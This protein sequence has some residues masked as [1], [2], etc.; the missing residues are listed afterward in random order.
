MTTRTRLLLY[1]P[2][3]EVGGS[4]VKVGRLARNLNRS[5]F[6]PIVAWS[7]RWGP[8][9]DWLTSAGVQVCRLYPRT[10]EDW[11]EQ[12]RSI[13]P[14]I[15]HSFSYRQEAT[16]VVAA[17]RAGVPVIITARSSTRHWDKECRVKGWEKIRN[18]LT[19]RIT[20]VSRAAADI[21]AQVEGVDRNEIS[22][23]YNGVPIP[24]CSAR[25]S[26][27]KRDLGISAS[28]RLAGCVAN[29][30]VEKGHALLIEAFRRLLERHPD[31]H[32]V[33]C[34]ADEFKLR[35]G[36]L[37]L[38]TGLGIGSKVTLL[39]L[40]ADVDSVYSA[41][42][43]YIQPSLADGFSNA[44]MEALAHGL[45][46]VATAVGGNPEAIVDGVTGLL[47]APNDP[48]ALAAAACALIDDPR[49][50]QLLG[51]SAAERA[52]R[53]SLPTMVALHE[54]LYEELRPRPFRL[55]ARAND[56]RTRILFHV[57]YL[58]AGGL[59]KNVGALVL[60][61]DKRR[62]DPIVSW[63][64]KSGPVARMLEDAGIPV[65]HINIP[66]ATAVERIA[67]VAPDIFHSF[68]CSQNS[69][70]V[71]AAQ[72][73]G[74]PVIIT[75]R[76]STRFWDEHAAVQG[77][78][79][80][81]NH[82]THKIIAC[83]RAVGE[84]ACSIESIPPDK[85][86]VIHNGVAIPAASSTSRALRRELSLPDTAELVGYAATYRAIKGHEFL[87]R[88]FRR[89]VDRRPRA[90][91][92]C[93]GEELDDTRFRLKALV[94]ELNL[95]SQVRLLESRT[96][97]DDVYSQLDVYAHPS[98]AEGFSLSILEAMS[99]ARPIVATA[100]GGNPEAVL[101]GVTG[102]LVAPRA[103]E[104]MADAIVSLLEDRDLRE[105]LGA[106]ARERVRRHFSVEAMTDAY[107]AIY[108]QVLRDSRAGSAPPVGVR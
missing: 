51:E 62:Y 15:F 63:S 10:E 92:V 6:E 74:V 8:V 80:E 3:L 91:L 90:H 31:T 50:A 79:V 41:L 102:I 49:R 89:V 20:A 54:R 4:E 24:E 14:D 87:L 22:I 7:D 36:L 46:C 104:A 29:Y 76:D 82:A 27:L 30:R 78:E 68:S 13:H 71:T 21:C 98:L 81:R 25:H 59:E 86:A 47:A 43:V 23:I 85:I 88:A 73:A 84:V 60:S 95:T 35:S 12:I 2:L 69:G 61:L 58:W 94:L 97:V 39:D 45:P 42:D 26:T 33:C 37:D 107:Q 38:A 99:H 48:A 96:D 11:T 9:G 56:G 101:D 65:H 52:R 17:H 103:V 67:Q 44:L 100:V 77:W 66:H 5:T 40:R 55:P 18:T 83:G 32:L 75:N 34:G 105:G 70:D 106:A 16:D 93:C 53:F 19:T 28:T 1:V 108:Q 57:D 72:A 64:R